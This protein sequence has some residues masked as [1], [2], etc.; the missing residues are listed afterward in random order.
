M[1]AAAAAATTG[2][3]TATTGAG[4]SSRSE[5]RDTLHS[6]FGSAAS[7]SSNQAD[8]RS[9]PP[10]NNPQPQRE[11]QQLSSPPALQGG[12]AARSGNQRTLHSFL[13]I[14]DGGGGGRQH[15]AAA[16]REAPRDGGG[17]GSRDG[18]HGAAVGEDRGGGDPPP[19]SSR[20]FPPPP[21]SDARAKRRKTSSSSPRRPPFVDGSHPSAAVADGAER[22]RSEG[23]SLS[24]VELGRLRD[25]VADLTGRLDEANARNDAIRNNQTLMGAELQRRLRR[26]E[27]ELEDA[28]RSGEARSAA[29]ASAMERLVRDASERGGRELRQRLAGDGARL[30]RLATSR[31]GGLGGSGLMRSHQ[32][33]TIETWEDGHAPI[34]IRTRRNELRTR[35]EGLERRWEDLSRELRCD[36]AGAAAVAVSD[37][38]ASSGE[39]RLSSSTGTSVRI[40]GDVPTSGDE[41]SNIGQSRFVATNDLDRME[42]MATIRMHLDEVRKKEIELDGEERALNVEKRAHVRA[43]KLVSNEESSKFRARR[44]VSDMT[45]DSYLLGIHTGGTLSHRRLFVSFQLHDRYFLMN[46]LGKGGFSEVWRAFDLIEARDVAVKI[47]Q[48]EPSWS[49]AKKENYTKHVSREYEI[50]REVRHPRIVSLYDVFEIDTDSFATVLEC[51]DGTD[52]DTLL[53]DRGRLPERDARA[54]LLQILCGMRYLSAPSADGRRQGI[55]HYDLKPG[56][57]LFDEQGNAKM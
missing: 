49:D 6:Y 15:A 40:G 34:A 36:P 52:L 55:I 8:A 21:S 45:I 17:G 2:A 43:L 50:H 32:T 27:A 4:E 13:G 47:H 54:I 29:A 18:A 28:R 10:R 14:A 3:T 31:V 39:L 16:A 20:L 46:L 7:A 25:Q 57:I 53:K 24:L 26:R 37:A 35:R 38:V 19:S 22:R 23:E 51:C 56:N 9:N 44:K 48:L 30:G 5:S 42:A 33:N 1:A 11:Q 12:R 41:S